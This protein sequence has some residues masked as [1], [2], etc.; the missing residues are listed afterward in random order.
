[1]PSLS[2]GFGLTGFEAI[3]AGTPVLITEESGLADWLIRLEKIEKID[4]GFA[5]ACIAR[6]VFAEGTPIEHWAEKLSALLEDRNRSFDRANALRNLLKE[7]FTWA[8]A[9]ARFAEAFDEILDSV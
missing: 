3:A 6:V 7:E 2:E 5:D 8:N 9:A 4:R 1:M